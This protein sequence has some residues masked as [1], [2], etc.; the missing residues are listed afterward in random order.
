MTYFNDWN[1]IMFVSSGL[2]L[3]I[4]LLMT[5]FNDWNDI[6]FIFRAMLGQKSWK[7]AEEAEISLTE[8]EECIPVFDLFL[9]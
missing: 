6:M 8:E 1:D 4:C 9:R 5:Y 7:E 2:V 3:R